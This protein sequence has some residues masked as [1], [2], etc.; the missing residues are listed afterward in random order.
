MS[1]NAMG[2][3]MAAEMAEQPRVLSALVARY[4]DLVSAVRG[5]AGP[6]V[7]GV[8][9]LARGS[10]DHAALLG[11]YAVELSAGLPTC[12]LAPSLMTTYRR[13]ATGFAGWLVIAL[14]QSG[15]TPE[16]VTVSDELATAGATV[17][18]VTNDG[19][20]PL[21]R[22]AQLAIDV[23]AGP[24]RAVPATKT[25]T[26]QM[27]A[28]LAVANGLGGADAVRS[29]VTCLPEAVAGLLRDTEPVEAAVEA[30]ADHDRLAVV[31]RGA[32]YPAA[33]ETALKMQETIGVLAHGFSTADF[34][35]GP[36]AV[37][38]PAAPAVLFAGS[39]P[40]DE[41]TR[42][43]RSTLDS[44]GAPVVSVGTGQD[45]DV[46]FPPLGHLAECVLATVRGQQLALALCRSRGIDPDR[47]AGLNKVTLTH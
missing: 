30:L 15:R 26:S 12:L 37:S 44:R 32:C 22:A 28:V 5:V 4:D 29:P 38:G 7:A 27:L 14:S 43:L 10:S 3:L 40:A 34:R 46:A 9:F 25:V 20:S 31:G 6:G 42:A 23:G 39:G 18:A 41:D 45:A 17:V 13:R 36:I 19:T 21:A 33:L 47:P 35:H 11:R 8:A 24:E 2:T 16:I 1:T